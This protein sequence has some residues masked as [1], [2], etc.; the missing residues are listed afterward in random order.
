VGLTLDN[1]SQLLLCQSQD[2]PLLSTKVVGQLIGT[3]SD[4]VHSVL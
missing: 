1:M 3:G 2:Q 4:A